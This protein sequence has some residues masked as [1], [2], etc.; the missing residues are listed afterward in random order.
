MAAFADDFNR[1]DNGWGP[2]WTLN[3]ESAHSILTNQARIR[4]GP[5]VANSGIAVWAASPSNASD[6]SSQAT[7]V[8]G[9][10]IEGRMGVG[11]RLIFTSVPVNITGYVALKDASGGVAAQLRRCVNQRPEDGTLVGS[12]A[13]IL[14]IGQTLRIEIVGNTITVKIAG[15]TVITHVDPTPLGAGRPGFATGDGTGGGIQSFDWLW[16]NWEGSA[17]SEELPYISLP[18]KSI[19]LVQRR[20][21]RLKHYIDP[22]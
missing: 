4:F 20:P 18:K 16:D 3:T 5:T 17:E 15:T 21:L 2:N 1:A 8:G 22:Y 14:G 13:T 7:L 11:V 9:N 6:Q 10:R 19:Q 12:S